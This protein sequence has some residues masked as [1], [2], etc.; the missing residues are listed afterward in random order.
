MA[1]TPAIIAIAIVGCAHIHTPSFVNMIKHRPEYQV[2]A[3]WDADPERAKKCAAELQSTA[4]TDLASIWKDPDIK[5]AIIC[6][7]TNRHADLAI[8]A[9]KAG[10]HVF[11]EKPLGMGAEDSKAIADAVDQA[12]VIFQ[13]GYFQ[14]GTATNQFLKDC[15]TS[16]TFG[17][18]TRV[19]HSNCHSGALGGLFDKEWRWMADPKQAGVGGFGDLGAHSVDLLIWLMGDVDSVTA[20][21][22]PGTNRYP[23]ADELGEGLLRFKSGAIGTVGA[24]WDDVSNPVQLLI[25]GT[26]GHAAIMNDSLYITSKKL[27][28]ADG[29]KPWAQLPPAKPHAFALFLDAVAGQKGLPLVTAREAAYDCAVMEALYKGAAEKKWVDIKASK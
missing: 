6:S 7:E 14:R 13:T 12:G 5:A 17:K 23:P 11:I 18:I 28:G 16:G 15:I 26:E 9:A 2:K 1:A 4:T 27:E 10:K 22:D 21:L 3:V 19:R 20:A 8:P 24:S 25:A 29:K